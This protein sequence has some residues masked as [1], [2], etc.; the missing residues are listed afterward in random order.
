MRTSQ[1]TP[2]GN[3][4]LIDIGGHPWPEPKDEDEFRKLIIEGST[5]TKKLVN[6]ELNLEWL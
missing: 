4:A 3:Q 6:T 1:R 5:N 2:K